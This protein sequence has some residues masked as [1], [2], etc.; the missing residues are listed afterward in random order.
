MFEP[1]PC[2]VPIKSFELLDF[3]ASQKAY[4]FHAKSYSK[5]MI[6]RPGASR[7]RFLN[8][9]ISQ[10]AYHVHQPASPNLINSY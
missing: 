3:T 6:L 8:L 5:A 1:N 9:A 4:N 2:Y 7:S 10:K